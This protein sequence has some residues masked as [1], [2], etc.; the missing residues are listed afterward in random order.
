MFDRVI[1]DGFYCY[2]YKDTIENSQTIEFTFWECENDV[3]T[4]EMEIYSKRKKKSSQFLETT[5]KVGIKGLLLARLVLQ[6]FID[7]LEETTTIGN[8]KRIVVGASDNRRKRIYKHYLSRLGFKYDRMPIVGGG[9]GMCLEVKG[10]LNK[11]LIYEN[12]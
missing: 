4:V 5:G 7:F 9:M 10:K 6:C 2:T 8:S 12:F 11:G 3:F 1:R